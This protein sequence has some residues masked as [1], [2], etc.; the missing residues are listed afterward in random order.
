[1]TTLGGSTQT[2]VTFGSGVTVTL[3]TTGLA[4]GIYAL[5]DLDSLT[6]ILPL[7]PDPHGADQAHHW[8]KESPVS[9]ASRLSCAR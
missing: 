6:A 4:L 7:P 1:M 8:W 3:D 5:I 9:A 2:A